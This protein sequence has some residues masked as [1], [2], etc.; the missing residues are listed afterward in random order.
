MPL[1]DLVRGRRQR[2]ADAGAPAAP[3]PPP[4]P[5]ALARQTA[6]A[7]SFGGTLPDYATLPPQPAAQPQDPLPPA[8]AT[9]E[10]T[11]FARLG[12]GVG[13]PGA[14]RST[15]AGVD[16]AADPASS[17]SAGDY[18]RMANP[19]TGGGR[20]VPEH[21]QP[22]TRSTQVQHGVDLLP[23]TKAAYD[24]RFKS[25]KE[26]TDAA[27]ELSTEQAQEDVNRA[28]L[29]AAWDQADNISTQ[30]LRDKQQSQLAEYKD[31][32]ASTM[33]DAEDPPDPHKWWGGKSV[34]GKVAT[35]LGMI[36]KGFAF[37]MT[38]GKSEDPGQ[39]VN[40][41]IQQS[42]DAQKASKQMAVG[43]AKT[44]YDEMK[45]KMGDDE[46][47]SL[48]TQLALRQNF[49]A[50]LN[51]SAMNTQLPALE[52]MRASQLQAGLAKDQSE[53]RRQ[54]DELTA[55]RVTTQGVEHFTP[56]QTIG[57]GSRDPL[58]LAERGAKLKALLIELGPNNPQAQKLRSE[59]AK[60]EAEAEAERAKA[61]GGPSDQGLQSLSKELVAAHIPAAKATVSEMNDLLKNDVAG[62]RV[63]A[64]VNAEP[65]STAR[66]VAQVAATTD[67]RRLADLIDQ[68]ADAEVKSSGGRLTEAMIPILK[69][70]IV[71]NGS[72]E[73]IKVGVAGSERK[74]RA[75]EGTIR[76]GFSPATLSEFDRRLVGQGV[77]LP[78]G[79]EPGVASTPRTTMA[80]T[81][82][83]DE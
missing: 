42:V 67:E 10:P 25:E 65:E 33:R 31:H 11:S 18:I 63:R 40:N 73:D 12:Q 60:N 19:N 4:D 32:L 39:W 64:L 27:V 37:G 46:R 23:E 28:K 71:G 9:R 55:D 76:A 13:Y 70:Q 72:P 1:I 34:A 21:W 79:F 6:A 22:G 41:Q 45:T 52:R 43:N 8:I 17:L 49:I 57:G 3:A 29:A 24:R 7:S 75:N 51:A 15:M 44:L 77:N 48:A 16:P 30:L 58:V 54:L 59:I 74:I 35:G 26:G 66:G 78:P 38:D 69:R 20:V 61:G 80:P 14:A 2:F 68:L 53:T 50:S 81:G 83:D 56:R 47:A 62:W 5:D 82:E 36:L